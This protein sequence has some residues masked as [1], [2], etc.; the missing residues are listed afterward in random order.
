MRNCNTAILF[1]LFLLLSKFTFAQQ[2]SFTFGLNATY[3]SDWK[4]DEPLNFFNPE[5]GF[6]KQL[7]KNYW[8]STHLNVFYGESSLPNGPQEGL[9]IYRLIFSNDYQIEYLR[10]G[11]F[12]AIGPTISYRNEKTLLSD[13]DFELDIDPDRAHFDI[14]G[15]VSSGYKLGLGQRSS[16]DFKLTYRF[17]SGGVD[18]VSF[19]L[20]FRRAWDQ[21]QKH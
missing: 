17:Y 20:F 21:R 5:I 9:V 10:K 1:T 14:G 7:N 13:Y 6:S 2:N 16:L 18:P 12:V 11:G 4:E 3:F 19:G 15:I 8:V